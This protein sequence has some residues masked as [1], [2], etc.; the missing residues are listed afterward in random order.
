MPS[1]YG[2]TSTY[3]VYSTQTTGL[4]VSS[5]T[6]V[7]SATIQPSNVSG[8]YT[9]Y[10][11]P[12]LTNNV[13]V[14]LNYF[15]ND[16]T[17]WFGLDPATD[18]NTIHAYTTG[19]ALTTIGDYVFTNNEINLQDGAPSVLNVGS[20]TWSFNQDG[21]TRL[22]AFTL[23][24]NSGFNNQTL[25]SDGSGNVFWGNTTA[26]ST[27]TIDIFSGDGIQT[28]YHLST[29]TISVDYVEVV[30]GGVTQTP[31][32]SYGIVGQNLIFVQAPPAGV[33]NI[34]VRYFSLLVAL[35]YLGYT[36][37]QGPQGYTGSTGF[38]GSQGVQGPT[39]ADAKGYP[40]LY[41]TSSFNLSSMDNQD[42]IV[43][44][45]VYSTTSYAGG[46]LV[47][48]SNLNPAL[49]SVVCFISL[50]GLPGNH[51]LVRLSPYQVISGSGITSGPWTLSPTGAPGPAGGYTGSQGFVGS[52]GPAG[53]YTGSRGFQGLQGNTGYTGSQGLRGPAGGYTGSL[54]YTGSQGP[55][56]TPGPA[57]GYTG[58]RGL[59]GYYGSQGI[60]GPAGGYT[61]SRGYTG[62]QGATGYYGS[63]GTSFVY[64]GNW[65]SGQYYYKN[66]IVTYAGAAWICIQITD[67]LTPPPNLPSNWN[68]WSALGYTGSI[69]YTGSASTAPGYAGSAGTNGTNGYNGSQGYTGSH[70]Y[71]G[72]AGGIALGTV[73]VNGYDGTTV[74]LGNIVA[75]IQYTSGVS[76][77]GIMSANSSSTVWVSG[78]GQFGG[79]Y[80][81][82]SFGYAAYNLTTST[83]W[84][85]YTG[86]SLQVG[87]NYEIMYVNEQA[88]PLYRITAIRNDNAEGTVI[89]IEQIL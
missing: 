40:S 6:S 9:G 41:T 47:I 11:T 32:D 57:G 39:G 56:G 59:M 65:T 89:A 53:G 31:G 27:A 42:I 10:T 25:L 33:D 13:E 35:A 72:S 54:G 43:T 4:Y 20:E 62:S 36:G 88:G 49:G 3:V 38:T 8:L 64:Q 46:N 66:D 23:P 70:G 45:D 5:S 86:T 22:P 60:Q 55:Q 71:T 50:A 44:Q 7:S 84:F 87:S 2:S 30:V 24:N 80:T 16:G 14:L 1:L 21:T 76:A 19:S 26:A 15:T 48:L 85:P 79:T 75:T 18:N 29:S 12:G 77:L 73:R 69:G 51:N 83:F 17:V 67:D 37:S 28:V 78:T 52:Q 82:S 58:S 61:G 63:A 34:Q 74:T 81:F 68:L